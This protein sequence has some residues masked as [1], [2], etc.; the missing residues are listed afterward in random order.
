MSFNDIYTATGQQWQQQ[1]A[2][3][4]FDREF[5]RIYG[6]DQVA[7]WRAHYLEALACFA[8]L[9]CPARSSRTSASTASWNPGS[10]S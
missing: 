5:A 2:A 9:R 7:V 1:V 10:R 4:D 6:L 8:A 3:G